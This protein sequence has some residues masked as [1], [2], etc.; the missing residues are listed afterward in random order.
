MFRILETKLPLRQAALG[1]SSA[2][3]ARDPIST[4]FE[5]REI[6]PELLVW[7]MRRHTR[8]PQKHD[9]L[10][11]IDPCR[12]NEPTSCPALHTLCLNNDS[13]ERPPLGSDVRTT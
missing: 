8:L 3:L 6:G 13:F 5:A 11:K 1:V 9:Q 7:F 10:K 2:I 12:L 4:L